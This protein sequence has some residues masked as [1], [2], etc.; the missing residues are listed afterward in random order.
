MAQAKKTDYDLIKY[1]VV[2]HANVTY[3]YKKYWSASLTIGGYD[4]NG[5]G[6]TIEEAY[7]N[8]AIM[9]KSSQHFKL[10]LFK[11]YQP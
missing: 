2:M 5:T 10:Q 9:I 6:H 3:P 1:L 7:I 11:M 8:L 4:A